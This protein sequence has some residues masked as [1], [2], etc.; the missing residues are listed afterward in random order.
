M[1]YVRILIG[2]LIWIGGI[3]AVW[4]I[5]AGSHTPQ[6]QANTAA[7]EKL[8][9]YATGHRGTAVLQSQYAFDAEVGDPIFILEGTELR[10]VGE[11][12]LVRDPDSG[13]P[14][15]R[16]TVCSAEAMLYSSAANITGD[17]RLTYYSGG[18]SLEWV[19]E[20]MLPPAKR[21][22][23]TRM[24]HRAYEEHHEEILKA[25]LPIVHKSLREG[26]L[27]V[28]RD[29]A[30]SIA[31]H[32][33]ELEELGRKYQKD[34]IE[35]KIVPLV[36]KDI[37]PIVQR[38]ATPMAETVGH[39][40]WDK[41]PMWGIMWRGGVDYVPYTR[42]TRAKERWEKYMSEE[43]MPILESHAGDFVRVVQQVMRDVS[44]NE[45]VRRVVRASVTQMVEDPQLQAIV[46]KIVREVV[47]DNP[48]LTEV[49]VRNWTGP[50]AKQALS[51][52][53]NRV[54]PTLSQ[55][56][57][58]LFG[59]KEKGFTPE[60][61]RVLR[62]RILNKDRRWFVLEPSPGASPAATAKARAK[63]KLILEVQWAD[64]A[65]LDPF[66]QALA[67]VEHD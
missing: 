42:K 65:A 56:G 14:T 2:L 53:M 19:L 26:A 13:Q 21:Q 8:W 47:I 34:I 10:R 61:A 54:D 59:T 55:I 51:L 11:I 32:K 1:R 12:A 29:L 52:A 50:E 16:A 64:D 20:T 31:A 44:Q 58:A 33:P 9:E 67:K 27:V 57:H 25:L 5:W 15:R 49:L 35:D 24:V 3:W 30:K 17:A 7:V 66:L 62:A 4:Q 40:L 36:K 48:A 22:Q 63:G 23:I 46:W 18:R 45:E 39:E 60:F 37:W 28:E 41:L 6:S 38:H 43:A